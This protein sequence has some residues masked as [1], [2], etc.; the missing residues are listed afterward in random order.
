MANLL[1]DIVNLDL[2]VTPKRKVVYLTN[3]EIPIRWLATSKRSTRSV[4]A[5]KPG[6]P[7]R[8]NNAYGLDQYQCV[9]EYWDSAKRSVEIIDL[10]FTVPALSKLDE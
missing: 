1:I 8:F 9:N 6:L 10:A 3:A 2:S 4:L 7:E 5:R